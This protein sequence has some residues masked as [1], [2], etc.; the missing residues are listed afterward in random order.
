[1][2]NQPSSR[3]GARDPHE[4]A[5]RGFLRAGADPLAIKVVRGQVTY[6][7]SS[8]GF[9][10]VRDGL[11]DGGAP[12]LDEPVPA[13]QIATL[14]A[15]A[16]DDRPRIH[17]LRPFSSARFFLEFLAAD[18]SVVALDNGSTA[19]VTAW[20]VCD[21]GAVVRGSQW[22]GVGH[23]AEVVDDGVVGRLVLYQ[24]TAVALAAPAARVRLRVAGEGLG[25]VE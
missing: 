8:R 23:R 11:L 6:D 21:T 18:G 3:V 13:A 2:P 24:L 7:P 16:A 1:M 10:F 14:Q 5:Q 19:T 9:G 20:R 4:L 22:A 25:F 12:V 17:D 15:A